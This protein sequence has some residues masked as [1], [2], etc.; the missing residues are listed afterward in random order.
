MTLR[1]W[2]AA[3]PA[4]SRLRT[5]NRY[6]GLTS[7]VPST[8]LGTK[9]FIASHP[10][11]LDLCDHPELIPLHGALS[12]KNPVVQELT[13]IFSL[14]KTNLHSDILGVPTEQFVEQE[15]LPNVP[16]SERN[17]EK[18]LW[19][20]SN[21]GAYYD[22]S[23]TWRTSHRA[24]LLRLGNRA[25]SIGEHEED[26]ITLL[27]APKAMRGQTLSTLSETIPWGKANRHYMDM[28]FTGSPLRESSQTPPLEM[29]SRAI[30]ILG[31]NAI[32]RMGLVMSF[33]M[34]SDGRIG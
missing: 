18:L 33:E 31:Q 4:S 16:W 27:P 24:R 2:A 29:L 6:A 8:A 22:A 15:E 34:N 32:M 20:G 23:T 13:P 1:G 10:A 19:R 7:P 5:F 17:Q 21:T 28:A 12:G 3:C 14:S 26:G 9:T 25:W 11:L 30:L